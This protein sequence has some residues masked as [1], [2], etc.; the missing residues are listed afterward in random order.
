MKL[1]TTC[2]ATAFAVLA[3]AG[4]ATAQNPLVGIAHSKNLVE[5]TLTIDH[6]TLR[7]T[8]R[9]KIFDSAGRPMPLERVQTMADF[10]A[11]DIV[12]AD[13]VAYAYEAADSVLV[14]LRAT[15]L[16]R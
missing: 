12:D 3:L 9:T 13:Q 7:V 10:S 4:P 8:E 11:T 16:P 14:M 15:T 1:V 2:I 5:R 6:Q